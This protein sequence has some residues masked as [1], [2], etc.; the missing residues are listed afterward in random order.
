MQNYEV[1]ILEMI[2][3]ETPRQK[4][5]FLKEILALFKENNSGVEVTLLTICDAMAGKGEEMFKASGNDSY[6]ERTHNYDAQ[7]L[8]YMLTN[9][10]KIN[11]ISFI[12]WREQLQNKH[13]NN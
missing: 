3:G 9:K 4:H 13:I 5:D 6:V 1:E 11:K 2:P 12:K 7:Q 10:Q 8:I